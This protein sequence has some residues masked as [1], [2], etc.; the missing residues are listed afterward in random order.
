MGEG[1]KDRRQGESSDYNGEARRIEDVM[2]ALAGTERS[3]MSHVTDSFERHHEED[4]SALNEQMERIKREHESFR[5]DIETNGK[6]LDRVV[7][8]IY[9]P[10]EF[11][12]DGDP[13]R[14]GGFLEDLYQIKESV[15]G[16]DKSVAALRER[17]ENGGVPAKVR[18]T[19]GQKIAIWAIAVPVVLQMILWMAEFVAR[20]QLPPG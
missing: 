3:L 6:K 18:L 5:V 12:V 19:L 14:E 1:F 13:H 15:G 9:G 8:A 10:K 11:D 4:H 17:S 16:L 20:N 2:H 7:T